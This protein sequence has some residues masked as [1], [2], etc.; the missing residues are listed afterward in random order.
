MSFWKKVALGACNMM[1]DYVGGQMK[2]VERYAKDNG[3]P[4]KGEFYDRKESYERIRSDVKNARR[5][6]D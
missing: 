1:V 3:K 6:M 5:N 2:D 4:L